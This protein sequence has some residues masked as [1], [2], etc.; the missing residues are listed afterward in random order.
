MRKSIGSFF[1]AWNRWREVEPMIWPVEVKV[2]LKEAT[3]IELKEDEKESVI[4]ERDGRK[5][6]IIRTDPKNGPVAFLRHTSMKKL[7]KK[8][9]Q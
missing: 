3:L 8:E 7:E 4:I 5:Y 1:L 9:E 2:Y 6:L